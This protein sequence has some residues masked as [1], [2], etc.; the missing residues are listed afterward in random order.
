MIRTLLLSIFC[1]LSLAGCAEKAA[2]R[3]AATESRVLTIYS[4]S[5]L[6]V[7]QPVIDDFRATHREIEV[8]YVDLEAAELD[9]RFR[10]ESASDGSP[11]DLLLSAAMDLQVR[12]VND[13]FAAPH[14]SANAGMVPGW[15]RWRDEALGFTFEPVVM[16]FNRKAMAGR[17]IPM[18]RPELLAAVRADPAFWRG[19]IGTYDVATSSVGYLVASQDARQSSD[20]GAIAEAFRDSGMVT[21]GTTSEVLD[22]IESGELALGYNVLGSYARAQADRSDNLELVYPSDYTLAVARTAVVPKSAPNARAAHQFLEYLLSIRGQRILTNRSR[23]SAVRPEINGPYSRLGITEK[24]VGPLRP[25]TLGPG[26]LVYL[27]AQKRE[28]LL[29]LWS[30][31]Q[32]R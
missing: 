15:A 7:F 25:I 2:D 24:S 1:L 3:A 29:A 20:F 17:R 12:L 18:S 27:D 4:T 8:K 6:E 5:D 14:R 26:L 31:G 10:A 22:R 16:V 28:R 9:R 32:P 19:R 23:L 30:G 11:A 21:A 13:G